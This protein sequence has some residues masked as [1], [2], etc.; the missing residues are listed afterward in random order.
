MPTFI[1]NF[2]N[3]LVISLNTANADSVVLTLT[4]DGT[5]QVRAVLTARPGTPTRLSIN[6]GTVK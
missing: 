2:L 3:R 6:G 4:F 1:R 5:H